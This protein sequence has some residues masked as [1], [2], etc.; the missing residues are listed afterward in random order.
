MSKEDYLK[1]YEKYLAGTC[2]Q[3]EEALLMDYQDGFELLD[4]PW[5]TKEMGDQEQT[6]QMIFNRLQPAIRPRKVLRLNTFIRWSAAAVL[7]L[8]LSVSLYRLSSRKAA[9]QLAGQTVNKFFKND[10]PPGKD[11]AILTLADGSEIVLEGKKNGI[12]AQ[13]GTASL[14]ID[15]GQL[16]YEPAAGPDVSDQ[17]VNTIS[18]PRGGKYQVILSDGTKVWLNAAS[19]LSFPAVFGTKKRVVR[20]KGEA[21]F[22]VAKSNRLS[23]VNGKAIAE[24]IPFIVETA[25]QSVEVL[26]T[27]FN[28]SSY[29]EEV[30]TRT[31]LLEGSVRVSAIKGN[32]QQL[33]KPGQQALLNPAKGSIAVSAANLEE[34]IAWKND[35]FMFEDEDIHSIMRKISR[36]YDVEVVYKGE[37]KGTKFGGTASRSDNLSEVLKALELTGTIHFSINGRTVTVMP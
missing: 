27:H 20:L 30:M 31:T 26:G 6:R 4:L 17:Q 34:A 35:I 14:R 5:D 15:G 8:A 7:L 25:A 37:L 12:L 9:V 19:S 3:V 13:Q 2:S 32:I 11:K 1:L 22:E 23:I 33:L 18:M 28:I 10:V 21:Y 29:D 16:V 36:W 24:R